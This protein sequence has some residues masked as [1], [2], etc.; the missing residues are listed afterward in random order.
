M[1]VSAGQ[2]RLICFALTLLALQSCQRV[3]S[4]REASNVS[5]STNSRAEM[6]KEDG[7]V[8]INGGT[9]EMGTDDGMPYEAPV[10]EVLVNSFWMDE[11]EVT[12]AEFTRFVEATGYRTDAEKFG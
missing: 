12:V 6:I 3:A 1:K 5:A 11:H 2:F 9:F 8:L 4:R 10:H 7:M